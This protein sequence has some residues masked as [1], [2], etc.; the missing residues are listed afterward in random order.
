MHIE[1]N[2]FDKFCN[3]V[4]DI[5]DKSRDNINA[6]MDLKE[7]CKWLELELME[8][9]NGRIYKPKAKF[10]LTIEQKCT[11]CEWVKKFKN[12]K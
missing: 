2:V 12:A 3:T 7:H 1:K 5:K 6:S 4:M 10:S 9:G 8:I 11:I